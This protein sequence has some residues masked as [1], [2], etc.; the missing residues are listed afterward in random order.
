MRKLLLHALR[1]LLVTTGLASSAAL[2]AFPEI[3]ANAQVS[4]IASYAIDSSWQTGY[5]ATVTIRNNS[6]APT[7]SWSATFTLPT[8]E[9]VSSAWN[10]V[11]TSSGQNF[12]VQNP[13]WFE[14]GVIPV[15]GSVTFGMIVQN[16]KSGP[17]L[18]NNLSAVGNGSGG[19]GGGGGTTIPSAPVLNQI[20]TSPSSPTSYTVSWN[21]VTG[22][23]SYTLQQATN[24]SFT[25]ATNVSQSSATSR[26]F[27]NQASGT[28]YYRVSATNSAGTSG[29]SNT[30]SVTVSSS[31]QLQA[32]VLQAISNPN[33][34]GS[35]T[36]S[37]SS[38]PNAQQYVLQEATSASFSN[39]TTV[40]TTT[41][42]SSQISGKAA[43][44]Y[45]YRVQ[46]KNG[47]TSSAFSNTVNTTVSTTPP[48]PTT[49]ALLETYWETWNSTDSINTIVNMKS[50][51][52][53]I[54]FGNFSRT[55]TNTYVVAG[56]DCDQATLTQFITAAHSAG[57]KVKIAI[58][59][60][61]YPISPT[62]TA[63]AAG[64]AKAVAQ[65]VSQNSLDGV[66]YDIENTPAAALQVALI[67]NTRQLLGS[68]AQITYT[69]PSPASSTA[70]WNSVIQSAHTYLDGINIMAYDYGSSYSYQQDTKALISMGVPASKITIGLMPGRDDV[71]VQTT[72]ANITTAANYILSSG[73]R[74]IMFWDLNRDHENLTGLGVDAAHN[75]AWNVFH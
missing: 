1:L 54:S 63:D 7:T 13:T 28:Y 6:Q 51:I 45:Y 41:S 17:V 69:P 19:G 39:P 60:A 26:A 25:G 30:Q 55:G 66:D 50:D 74:G 48:P 64:M 16:P 44:T 11:L 47:T 5:Q 75:T 24:A 42:T 22:A 71:G 58:G 3:N 32:P 43:G 70:P 8:S 20:S 21:S 40:A 29:F 65:F 2:Q 37:W 4:L 62:S 36:V 61:S 72:L 35:F 53:N 46:A 34:S 59:G 68:N 12:T 67:Q 57:K 14:G 18:L 15:G 33:N 56:L 49:K 38:V 52:I 73:L 27:T 23:T 9:T 31:T 10:G